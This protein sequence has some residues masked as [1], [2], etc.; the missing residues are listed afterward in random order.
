M[1]LVHHWLGSDHSF[2]AFD[3]EWTWCENHQS[4]KKIIA[5]VSQLQ[6]CSFAFL[7]PGEEVVVV[8]DQFVSRV[9]CCCLAER[10]G[11]ARMRYMAGHLGCC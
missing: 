2:M 6:S 9:G 4:L 3:G 7:D 1:V 10:T 5:G 11:H 8:V